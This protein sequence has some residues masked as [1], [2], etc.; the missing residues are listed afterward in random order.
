V[1]RLTYEDVTS[2]KLGK[3]LA[4]EWP[5]GGIFSSE[6]GAVLGGH[7][8]G[9]DAIGRTLALL[10]KLW[11]GAPHIVDRA[12]AA[13]FAVRGARMTISLQVQPHVLAD[14]LDRDRGMSRGSGFL[15]RFLVSQPM[16]LQG[17]RLYKE[18]GDMPELGLFSSR[19]TELLSDLPQVDPDRGLVLP[20]LDFTADAKALWVES[21]NA[22]E[23]ELSSG[24]DFASIK[25]AASKAA[26]NIA[27][28]AAVLHVFE[29]GARGPISAQS[30]DA[31]RRIVLWHAY[32]ARALFAPLTL[33]REAA[34]AAT[35]D[36]WL[37]D[38]CLMEGLDGFPKR[39]VLQS[40]PNGTRKGEDLDAAL[41]ILAA[42]GRVRIVQAGRRRTVKV[43][44]AL[45]DG[46]A[47][48]M[49]D[50]DAPDIAPHTAPAIWNG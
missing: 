36:R 22:I 5:S 8:M 28:L 17:T 16:S 42:H 39:I 34:N 41:E 14:F 30:V 44:P 49:S 20:L 37:I 45:L 7:S 31:A 33:S 18:S 24:G 43:N 3:S 48:A 6:G 2:E 46:T 50:D 19:I 15:A 21:Y 38:R 47:E 4:T 40:G 11:D 35:L 12:T 27:R 1:P 13:S 23:R 29:Y 25:D 32:S 26:D 10:N 9:K